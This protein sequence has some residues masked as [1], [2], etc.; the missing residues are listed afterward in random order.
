MEVCFFSS[1]LM[2]SI[3]RITAHFHIPWIALLLCKESKVVK[4][5]KAI[6]WVDCSQRENL[7]TEYKKF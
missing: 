4:S 3:F 5:N 1:L 7:N 2:H 6:G